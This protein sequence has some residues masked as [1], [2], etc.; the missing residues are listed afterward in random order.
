MTVTLPPGLTFG[1]SSTTRGRSVVATRAFGPGDTISIF[2]DRKASVAVPDVPHLAQ[3]CSYCLA[4]ADVDSDA[5]ATQQVSVR[6]CTACRTAHYCSTACQKA[7]WG[8]AHG[9]GECKAFKRVRA[10]ETGS[11]TATRTL[12]TPTR[13][14]IQVLLRPDMQAAI[15]ELEGHVESFRNADPQAWADIELQAR[16]A[17]HYL[18]RET[19]PAEVKE[20]VEVSCKLRVN[21]FNRTDTDLGQSGIYINTALAMVDHSCVPNAFVQ[22]TGRKAILHAFREIKENEEIEISYIDCTLHR[23]QRQHALKTRYHFEC[24]CLRCT[25]DMD[26]YQVCQMYPHLEL[27]LF[28]LMPDLDKLRKP[29][30]K[31][32]L[33]SNK[34]LQHNVDQI[35]LSCSEPLQE[36]SPADKH[37][38][39]RRRWRMCAKLRKVESYA[40]EPLTQ[41]LVE[42][43][44]YFSIQ[45]N[46]A[47][48]LAIACFLALNSDPYKGPMP[49]FEPRV[50]RMFVMAKLLTNTAATTDLALSGNSA[51]LEARIYQALSSK[52]QA[53]LC[54]VVLRIL[55]YYCPA[56]HS[57][58]W[59]IYHQAKDLLND[60]ESL[61]GRETENALINAFV[62]NP[63]G[64]D[65]RRFFMTAVLYPIQALAEFALKAMETEFGT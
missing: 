61:P 44:V 1:P 56:A 26:V 50:R 11:G 20:A 28:S 10:P 4:V 40:V 38:E 9:K 23:S 59:Q 58:E 37:K 3:T 21:S 51:T 36:L 49:F 65:E 8:L 64:S 43:S 60:L 6:A 45:G 57:T 32:F 35:Y 25:D 24:I 46:F 55:I 2:A 17:L 62:R 29:S 52:D 42:A 5:P 15:A 33:H 12:P 22:F 18:G 41:V 14:L 19:G 13:A 53:T 31:Q 27:N 63:N 47:Y 39:L 7:D 54:Q 16:A 34:V 48:G 30:V